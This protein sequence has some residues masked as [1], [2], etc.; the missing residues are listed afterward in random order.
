MVSVPITS[1][2][3]PPVLAGSLHGGQTMQHSLLCGL[4]SSCSELAS[5][6]PSLP[7]WPL[8]G[9][10]PHWLLS[11]P[12]LPRSSVF[13][14][15]ELRKQD[16]FHSVLPVSPVPEQVLLYSSG[17]L[18]FKTPQSEDDPLHWG[19]C[20]RRG[21]RGG[22]GG[23]SPHRRIRDGKGKVSLLSAW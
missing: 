3:S 15:I 17:I 20:V 18:P 4:A 9:S 2:W 16:M 19:G 13:W 12:S 21:S 7:H 22:M 23:N 1:L 6:E 8:G 14:G 11:S 10:L 5:G